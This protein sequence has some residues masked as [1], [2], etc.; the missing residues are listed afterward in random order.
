MT[1][2]DNY[3]KDP[4][5]NTIQGWMV[6]LGIFAKYSERGVAERLETSAQHDILYLPSKPD[7]GAAELTEI[8]D[9]RQLRGLG[10]HWCSDVD[11][12]GKFT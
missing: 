10:F 5:A 3:L 1:D 7:P 6:A 12:W 2:D 4:L 9:A 8:A 11:C